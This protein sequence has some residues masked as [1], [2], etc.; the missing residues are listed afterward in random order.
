M[1]EKEAEELTEKYTREEL[2]RLALNMGIE[3]AD[4]LPNK[5]TVALE[6]VKA[7]KTK[8]LTRKAVGLYWKD[9]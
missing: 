7:R 3:N 5:K 1:K 8:D 9:E 6:I 2:D 4:R